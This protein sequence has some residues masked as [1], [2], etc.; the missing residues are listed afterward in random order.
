MVF[1]IVMYGC[2]N[3]TMKKAEHWRIDAVKL[4]CWRRVLRVTWTARRSNQEILK[5]IIPEYS[6]EG[7]MLRLK[8][9]Y[10]G[11]QVW[12]TECENFTF[13]WRS[14]HWKRPWC[15]ER[16][17]VGGERNDRGWDGWMSSPTQW[18]WV[19][20][21]SRRQWRAGKPG[22]L[23]S[24]GSQRVGHDWATEQLPPPPGCFDY[25]SLEE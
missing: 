5:E 17:K 11:H 16:L 25:C 20:A 24:M 8:L 14:F 23:Q 15:W 9:Q 18:T 12:R 7:L 4:W 22:V 6:L 13:Q 3:W 10:V 21:N 19:W 2:V 1:L